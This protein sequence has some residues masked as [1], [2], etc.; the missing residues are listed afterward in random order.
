MTLM[1]AG[2]SSG[3]SSVKRFILCISVATLAHVGTP[4]TA[5]SGSTHAEVVGKA[6]SAAPPRHG[7]G[8]IAHRHHQ[9]HKRFFYPDWYYAP[10]FDPVSEAPYGPTAE[11][12]YA[13]DESAPR[14]PTG[15]VSETKSVRSEEEGRGQVQMTIIH[16][17]VPIVQSPAVPKTRQ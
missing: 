15:C 6:T 7:V 9:H 4:V 8:S 1:P 16:C 17:N 5:F 13:P 3:E 2:K 14:V 10:D 12:D 11:N